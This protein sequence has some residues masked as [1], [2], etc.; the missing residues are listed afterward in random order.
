MQNFMGMD[1]FI[2]FTGVVEDRNDPSKLGRVRVRCVGYHTDD[3]ERI[4]TADLPWAHVMHPV[5]D[6]SMNGMGQT[7]SFMVEG[8]W[9]VGFFM[10]AEDKQQ[11]IIIGTLPGVPDEKPNTSKGFYDPNGVYPKTDF[12]EESDV[13]RLA[14]GETDNTIVPLKKGSR[15]KNIS[16]ADGTEWDEPETTYDAK[17]PSNHVFESESGHIIELDDTS[18]AERLHEYSSSGTFYEIDKDGN[19][20]ARVVGDN[21]EVFSGSHF[22]FT[23]K[24]FNLT[25]AGTLNIKCKN[26][27]IEVEEDYIDE[28]E[29]DRKTFVEGN[30]ELHTQ[31]KFD[32]FAKNT[33]NIDTASLDVDASTVIALTS[34]I[35]TLNGVTSTNIRGATVNLEGVTSN[36]VGTTVSIDGTTVDIDGTN[37]NIDT[38]SYNLKATT[39]NLQLV[40]SGLLPPHPTDP[41]VSISD[42][43]SPGTVSITDPTEPDIEISTPSA[44]NIGGGSDEEPTDITTGSKF[45]EESGA[46]FAGSNSPDSE[47]GNSDI[48][49]PTSTSCT[50]SDLG[51]VSAI[52]ESNKKSGALGY[53]RVG[54]H[55][56]GT[57]QIASGNGRTNIDGPKGSSMVS[58]AKFLRNDK[59][60][61][62]DFYTQ[63]G[64][65]SIPSD[66][67]ASNNVQNLNPN[68][69]PPNGTFQQKWYDLANNSETATRFK[70]AQHDWIQRTHYDPAVRKIKEST[71]IDFCDGFHSA[72]VQDAI[73]STSVQHG[74]GGANKIFKRA[75]ARTGKGI[76]TVTDEELINAIYDERFAAKDGG[77]TLD[78]FNKSGVKIGTVQEMKYFSGSTPLTQFNITNGR[79]VR[80]RP[81]ALALNTNTEFNVASL[82]P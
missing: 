57:Y 35:T 15:L 27:N 11:P 60:G 48:D 73:W 22:N 9:V 2:W 47:F 50:R 12:L 8:T 34:D 69:R 45:P 25:V 64:G 54:G 21:K 31:T 30:V 51:E 58:F 26:L 17:Y 28:I 37:V 67:A 74:S 24:D 19:R 33:V 63:L 62:R 79:A 42:I 71:G 82:S 7:P 13:N 38:S 66:A 39:S 49:P 59:N 4:P 52:E 68:T 20:H 53:D 46:P 16:L 5:T 41:S 23:Q 80:E 70:Q 65:N 72:G 10:D 1:G 40:A 6:P 76:D 56:Y 3:K 77:A 81:K 18:G 55:S 32:I 29:G 75:L 14:R 36:I 43:T 61:Y 44:A 78:V